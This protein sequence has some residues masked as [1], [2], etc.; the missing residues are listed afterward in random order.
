MVDLPLDKAIA[1]L[2]IVDAEANAEERAHLL[3]VAQ[4]TI[5][6]IGLQPD[7][8][9]PDTHLSNQR[10]TPADADAGVNVPPPSHFCLRHG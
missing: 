9:G 7:A 8:C 1:L 3:D 10:N 4:K 6:R 5:R 2:K